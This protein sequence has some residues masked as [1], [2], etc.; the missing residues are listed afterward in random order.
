MK[1]KLYLRAFLLALCCALLT[2]GAIFLLL[3]SAVGTAL[4]AD[5]LPRLMWMLPVA[6]CLAA[7]GAWLVTRSVTDPIGKLD[8]ENP[9]TEAPYEELVPLLARIRQQ[10]RTIRRQE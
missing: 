5:V 2:A 8:P 3:G 7:A 6:V 9:G 1:A 4:F 10:Q